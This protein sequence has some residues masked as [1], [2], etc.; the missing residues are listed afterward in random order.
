MADSRTDSMAIT[1]ARLFGALIRSLPAT[2]NAT[3]LIKY[4]T[5]LRPNKSISG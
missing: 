2:S 4:A 3:G 1:N 5:H